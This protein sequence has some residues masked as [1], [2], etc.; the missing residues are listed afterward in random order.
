M[1]LQCTNT[2]CPTHTAADSPAFTVRLTVDER[3]AVI[4]NPH[5]IGGEEFICCYCHHHA[6]WKEG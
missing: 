2:E 4:E 6:A 3:C 5:D 1:K